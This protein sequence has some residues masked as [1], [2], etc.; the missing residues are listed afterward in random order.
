MPEIDNILHSPRCNCAIENRCRC[1]PAW[2]S[3]LEKASGVNIS[4]APL[5]FGRRSLKKQCIGMSQP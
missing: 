4:G 2:L 5:C 1:M 3:V